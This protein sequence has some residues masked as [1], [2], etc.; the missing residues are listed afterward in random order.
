MREKPEARIDCEQDAYD[1]DDSVCAHFVAAVQAGI[2]HPMCHR[3]G[4]LQAAVHIRKLRYRPNFGRHLI[5]QELVGLTM[6]KISLLF[7]VSQTP[8]ADLQHQVPSAG[9]LCQT[10]VAAY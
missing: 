4:S 2:C 3:R 8:N 9:G 6:L 1:V 10:I 7:L 5:A